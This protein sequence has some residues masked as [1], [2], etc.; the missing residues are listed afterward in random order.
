MLNYGKLPRT[1]TSMQLPPESQK[2]PRA[3]AFLDKLRSAVR[4]ARQCIQEAIVRQKRFADAKRRDVEFEVGKKVLLSSKNIKY[5]NPGTRKL[6]PKF[7]GPFEVTERIGPVAYRLLLPETLKVHNVFHVNLLKEYRTDGSYQPPPPTILFEGEAEYEVECV[8]MHR[9]RKVSSKKEVL[10]FLVH[11][12][13][14]GPEHDTW[15]PEA[16]LANSSEVLREYW[17]TVRLRGPDEPRRA[18]ESFDTVSTTPVVTGSDSVKSRTQ[19]KSQKRKLPSSRNDSQTGT[20][21]RRR[22]ARISKV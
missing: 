5:K 18:V 22:R 6:M 11:W 7:I 1:P 20:Q 13:G 10:E 15:E 9:I 2:T 3:Y 14:Y 16:H 8:L 19:Q 4:Q 17:E 21:T 12:T